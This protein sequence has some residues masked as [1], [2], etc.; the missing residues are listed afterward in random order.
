MEISKNP[1]NILCPCAQYL[2]RSPLDVEKVN[3]PGHE[4]AEKSTMLKFPEITGLIY[5]SPR[6]H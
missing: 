6:G 3:R 1:Q 4:G 5:P 2:Q